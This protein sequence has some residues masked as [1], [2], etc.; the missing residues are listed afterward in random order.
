[1]PKYFKAKKN[2]AILMG[3]GPGGSYG[4]Y[5]R[6]IARHIGKHI[7]GKPNIIVEHM[8]GAGGA[9]AGNFIYANAPQDG[10]KIL[11][12]HAL[13]LVEKL[14]GRK[15]LKFKSEKFQWIGSF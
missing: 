13:P 7:P 3:T 1:M 6:V 5:G 4:L 10:S 14:S 2:I 12:T 15:N 9:N 8:P 11:M